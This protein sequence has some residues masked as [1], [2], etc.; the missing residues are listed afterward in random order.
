MPALPKEQ[1]DKLNLM[2]GTARSLEQDTLLP[3]DTRVWDRD[4]ALLC[5]ELSNIVDP[6]LGDD[7]R[8]EKGFYSAANQIAKGFFDQPPFGG[9]K[10]ATGQYGF[11]LIG[12]QDL[13]GST[14][15]NL[16]PQLWSWVQTLTT[17]SGAYTE[18]PTAFGGGAFYASSKAN[19][20]AILA[21]HRLISY[22]PA[23]RLLYL[24]WKVNDYPYAPYSVEPFSKIA[25]ADKL[26]KIVPMPGRII[27]HPGGKCDCDMYFDL[28]TGSTDPS[29]TT[30]IDVEIALFGIVFA[31]YDY[32]RS[33]GLDATV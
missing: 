33:E 8:G 27:L 2:A 14:T 11:R 18:V 22:K 20:S 26:F 10:P 5:D 17:T 21:W 28:E 25:K 13:K 4:F 15:T 32:L 19:A 9:L 30:N 23:P 31:E 3:E 7:L 12:P 24:Q 1:F 29:G 16:S 6:A